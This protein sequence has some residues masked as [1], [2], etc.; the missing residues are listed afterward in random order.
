MLENRQLLL[1]KGEGRK[2]GKRERGGE[3]KE[4]RKRPID[5]EKQKAFFPFYFI[6]FIIFLILIAV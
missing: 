5:L 6:C 2:N 3:R 1:K 4:E